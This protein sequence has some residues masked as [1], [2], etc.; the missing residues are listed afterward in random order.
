MAALEFGGTRRQPPPSVDNL[1]SGLSPDGRRS[2][3][4]APLPATGRRCLRCRT[5]ID[6]LSMTAKCVPPRANERVTLEAQRAAV[7]QFGP[8]W[9]AF[10]H[11][12]DRQHVVPPCCGHEAPPG[13]AFAR[14]PSQVRPDH[15]SAESRFP[16]RSVSGSGIRSWLMRAA[17]K[18]N[19]PMCSC[20]PCTCAECA[21]GVVTL[22]DLERRVL[23][24]VW[25]L[26]DA[27]PT[28]RDVADALPAHAY[29]TIATVLDRLVNKG[30]LSRRPDGRTIRFAPV[31][32]RGAHTAVVMHQALASDGDPSAALVCFADTLS[33]SEVAVLLDA[34]AQRTS[35][36]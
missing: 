30:L 34:L 26:P 22:G 3:F 16:V 23:G 8:A 7:D 2:T 9:I 19:N 10:C 12:G 35:A 5:P 21:C 4:R 18:C 31:G 29:T 11:R 20:D 36:D 25:D 32:V 6:L 13:S 27:E 1:S 17:T 28:G 15:G 24:I 33:H 14:L